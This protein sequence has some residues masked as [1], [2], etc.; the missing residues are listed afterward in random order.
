MLRRAQKLNQEP[1]FYHTFFNNCIM[2]I[3]RHLNKQLNTNITSSWPIVLPGF[4]DR[5][6]YRRGW[7]ATSLSFKEARNVFNPFKRKYGER[8]VVNDSWEFTRLLHPL[9]N[10]F[11]FRQVFDPFLSLIDFQH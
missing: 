1:E 9:V 6:A 8:L 7:L 5:Y 2:N 3:I 11:H 4:S 10:H